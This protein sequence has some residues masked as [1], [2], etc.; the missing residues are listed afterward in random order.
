VR[1]LRQ[2]CAT[3]AVAVSAGSPAIADDLAGSWYVLVHYQDEGTAHPERERWD[4]R[5]W[6]FEREAEKLRWTEFPTV[7]FEDDTGRFERGARTLQHWEP[8]ETQRDEVA[9]GLATSA[10]GSKYKWLFGSDAQGWSSSRARAESAASASTLVY[11]EIWSIE[12]ANDLPVFTQSVALSGA[13]ANGLQ[14]ATRF[15]TTEKSETLLVGTFARDGVRHG[16]FRMMR[17]GK[18]STSRPDVSQQPQP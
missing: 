16:T 7:G 13:G 10:L 17:S 18:A 11:S 5:M 3:L 4:D 6:I 9:K 8:S 15:A 1:A 14:G 12:F 2:L